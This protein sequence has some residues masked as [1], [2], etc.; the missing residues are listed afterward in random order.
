M[1]LQKSSMIE[2]LVKDLFQPKCYELSHHRNEPCD[3]DEHL[4]PLRDTFDKH[5]SAQKYS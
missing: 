2:V 4:C 1:M 5:K 3:G